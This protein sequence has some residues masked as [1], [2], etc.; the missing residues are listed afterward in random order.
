M[1]ATYKEKMTS[2]AKINPNTV[3]CFCWETLVNN[4]YMQ[5]YSI[6]R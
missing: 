2:R 6:L 3:A 1:I 4:S 5:Y